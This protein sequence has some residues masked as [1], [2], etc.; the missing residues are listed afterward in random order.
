M[1]T[2]T[3][4]ISAAKAKLKSTG[5]EVSEDEER[6]NDNHAGDAFG[7]KRKKRGQKS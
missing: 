7:G 6:D 2:L 4:K 5:E 1:K 3:A